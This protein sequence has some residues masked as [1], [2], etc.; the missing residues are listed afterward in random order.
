MSRVSFFTPRVRPNPTSPAVSM[1][2]G[3]TAVAGVRDGAT[4]EPLPWSEEKTQINEQGVS[5]CFNREKA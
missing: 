4:N 5:E 2:S 1:M 3:T